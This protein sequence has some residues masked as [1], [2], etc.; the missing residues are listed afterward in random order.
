MGDV[1]NEVKYFLKNV[2]K[3]KVTATSAERAERF[4]I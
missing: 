2:T 4:D 1:L 3:L